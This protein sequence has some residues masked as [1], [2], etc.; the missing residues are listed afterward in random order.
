[1]KLMKILIEISDYDYG[2]VRNTEMKVA[3]FSETTMGRV[4]NAIVSGKVE[5]EYDADN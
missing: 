5:E 3:E 2:K 4:Y 1:M